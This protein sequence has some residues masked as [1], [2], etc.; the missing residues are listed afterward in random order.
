MT[1]LLPRLFGDFGEFFDME[2]TPRSHLIR[3]EDTLTDEQYSVRAEIPGMDPAKDVHI[4]V[5][6]NMLT[7]RAERKEEEKTAGRSEFRYGAMRRTVR[8]PENADTAAI[9]ASYDKG[10]LEVTVPLTPD[11][12]DVREIPVT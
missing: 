11:A 10:I 12:P 3:V 7:I 9:R 4:T 6:N 8:L 2:L 1:A 5:A